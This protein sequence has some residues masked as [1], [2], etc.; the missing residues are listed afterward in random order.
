MGHVRRRRSAAGVPQWPS[1]ALLPAARGGRFESP[2]LFV[3]EGAL[4]LSRLRDAPH[5]CL[6]RTHRED[7]VPQCVTMT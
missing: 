2:P 4:E 1:D 7:R 3:C 5:T 6:P